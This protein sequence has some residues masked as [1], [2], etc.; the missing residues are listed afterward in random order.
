MRVNIRVENYGPFRYVGCSTAAEML[1]EG[2]KNIPELDVTLNGKEND[3]DIV[4]CHSL[5]PGAFLSQRRAKGKTVLTVHSVPSLNKGN[6]AFSPV[7]NAMYKPMYR[8]YDALITLTDFSEKE[9]RQMLPNSRMYR[10]SNGVNRDRFKP[11]AEK[12]S[13]F[14]NKYG[15]SEDQKVIL[16]V[17][18]QTPRKGIY[19]FISIARKL[20]E[21]QFVWVGG[22]AYGPFSSEKNDVQKAIQSAPSNLIFTG[23]VDDISAAYA[24]ADVFLFPSYKE[25]MPMSILEALSSGL[26]VIARE[27]HEYPSLYPGIAA[28]FK[29]IEE[30]IP[31]LADEELLQKAAANARDSVEKNDMNNV[32]RMHYELYKELIEE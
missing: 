11:D 21:Y 16:Q 7:I 13:N 8:Q 1:Y 19:D 6:L 20:P 14:R 5:G 18:Q 31:L 26:P 23:F 29:E 15:F 24:A 17:A 10:L 30:A 22:F 27:W 12:R 9:T 4:H 32:A 3:Y 2:L 25:I 28:Y